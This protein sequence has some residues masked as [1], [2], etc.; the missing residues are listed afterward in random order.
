MRREYGD[1]YQFRAP[2][3]YKC[4]GRL[5]S[6]VKHLGGI[7]SVGNDGESLVLNGQQAPKRL[8]VLPPLHL[9]EVS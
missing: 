1:L 2:Y 4:W 7:L 8:D 9:L 6:E 5:K 3:A